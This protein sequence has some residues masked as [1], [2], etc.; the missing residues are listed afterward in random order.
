MPTLLEIGSQMTEIIRLAESL[1]EGGELKPED[2]AM[3][4][5]WL[6]SNRAEQD[7]KVDGYCALIREFELR[8]EARQKEAER[9]SKL[10]SYDQNTADRLRDRL[11]LYMTLYGLKKIETERFR[12]SICGNGGKQ[13]IEVEIPA[14]QLPEE[15][16]RHSVAIDYDKIRD[17]LLAGRQ[18]SFARTKERGTHL[19]IA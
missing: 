17:D 8:S 6:A 12:A 5:Q 19:R 11:K 16:Q 4:D 1:A 10:A 14:D 7:R 18:L 9:L 2:A 15:Y 3:I 13:P